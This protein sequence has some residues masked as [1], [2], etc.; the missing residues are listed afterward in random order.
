MFEPR[1]LG[2]LMNRLATKGDPSGDVYCFAQFVVCG[3]FCDNC[4]ARVDSICM[5][6]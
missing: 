1:F 6:R 2:F 5:C 4:D 3:G